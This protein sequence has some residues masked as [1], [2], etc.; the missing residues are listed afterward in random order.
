MDNT[1]KLPLVSIC[2]IAYNQQKYIRQ[3]LESFLMQ[4]TDFN[5]EVIIHDD[6]STDGTTEIIREYES[7]FPGIIKPIFQTINKYQSEGL[8]FQFKYVFPKAKGKYITFCEGDDYWI[9]PLKLQ[10]QVDFLELH[11]DFGLVHTRA[12]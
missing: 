4:R 2:C 12:V 7:K 1:N 10:K 11:K 9:D 3:A 5:F 8:N 6:A